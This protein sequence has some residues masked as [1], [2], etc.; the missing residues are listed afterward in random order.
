M[1]GAGRFLQHLLVAALHRAVALEQI[2]AVA[3]AVA[4][5]W[6]SMWRGRVTMY[7]TS[8]RSSPKLGGLALAGRQRRPKSSPF[9]T[10]RMPFAATAGAGLD[11]HRIADGVGLRLEEG[12]S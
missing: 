10:S 6:I 9:S 2:D 5:T 1:P 11:Q 4:K 3:L 7:S 12:G 8:T